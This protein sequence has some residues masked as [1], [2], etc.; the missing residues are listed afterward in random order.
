MGFNCDLF[1]Q[2]STVTPLASTPLIVKARS[3]NTEAF[4]RAGPIRTDRVIAKLFWWPALFLLQPSCPSCL[5]HPHPSQKARRAGPSV[6]RYLFPHS[7]FRIQLR[8]GR[9]DGESPG[10][11][12]EVFEFIGDCVA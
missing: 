4:D 3:F 2:V 10:E 9:A 6:C 7:P 12:G 11:D 5:S 8:D 1:P